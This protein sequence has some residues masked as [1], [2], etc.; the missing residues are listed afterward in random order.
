[1]TGSS[2]TLDIHPHVI[3]PDAERYPRKI[4]G[5]RSSAWGLER[6][7]TCE[8]L[9]T[10]MDLAGI[11][12]AVV[13][14][15]SSIYGMDNSYV[16]DC[17]AAYPDRLAAVGSIDLRDER[18]PEHATYWVRERGLAG[19]RVFAAGSGS[20]NDTSA[21]MAEP[22]TFPV[23][24]RVAELGVPLCLLLRFTGMPALA[25]VLDRFP[26]VRVILD[27]FAHPP[28]GDAASIQILRDLAR[29]PNLFL[30]FSSHVLHDFDEASAAFRPFFEDVLEAFGS[31]RIAWGSNFP[32]SP[33]TLL[34]LLERAQ[35]E[36]AFLSDHDRDAIFSGTAQRLYP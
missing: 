12:R 33:G 24:E 5:G 26:Q 21:W 1:M 17:V 18:G 23:W 32:A 30:K 22:K 6:P 29:R 15:A 10:A 20:P 14:H 34:S 28:P 27:H 19:L 3:S 31:E 4:M 13:V 11:E 25:E 2:N 16:A 7:V 35:R 36:L 9:L 8:E